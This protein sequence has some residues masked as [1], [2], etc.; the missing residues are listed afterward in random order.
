MKKKLIGLILAIATV[1]TL[2]VPFTVSANPDPPTTELGD[3]VSTNVEYFPE[4]GFTV[5]EEMDVDNRIVLTL[6]REEEDIPRQEQ[7]INVFEEAAIILEAL[8]FSQL[9]IDTLTEEQ[10]RNIAFDTQLEVAITYSTQNALGN[11][12]Y[13]T[14]DRA[15]DIAEREN[16]NEIASESLLPL[17]PLESMQLSGL[18]T[19]FGNTPI[20]LAERNI[21]FGVMTV[22]HFIN[23]DIRDHARLTFFTEM[24]WLSPP[25][26]RRNDSLGSVASHISIC[27]NSEMSLWFTYTRNNMHGNTLISSQNFARQGTIQT[28]SYHQFRGVAGIFRFPYNIYR[29]CMISG[30]P[31]NNVRHSNLTALLTWTG[32]VSQPSVTRTFESVG[33]HYHDNTL[34]PTLLPSNISISIGIP[35]TPFSIGLRRFGLESPTRRAVPMTVHR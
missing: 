18:I 30:A 8:G 20:R 5:T 22:R 28:R 33:S 29:D 10:A 21:N 31:G 26:H 13:L 19:P 12:V 3:I 4:Y 9:T 6:E 23:R 2:A 25:L 34:L 7:D 24:R 15:Y 17:S 1:F 32:Y 16:N 14:P 11:D 27:H 35:N